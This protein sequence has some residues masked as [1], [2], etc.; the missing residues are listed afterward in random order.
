MCFGEAKSTDAPLL[1]CSAK[2]IM[3]TPQLYALVCC[4]KFFT[5]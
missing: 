1:I 3:N 5:L 4:G 2:V